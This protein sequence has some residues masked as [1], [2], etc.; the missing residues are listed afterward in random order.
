MP[1]S[2]Q[3]TYETIRS[4]IGANVGAVTSIMTAARPTVNEVVDGSI[5]GGS[6]EYK[7]RWIVFTSGSNDGRIRRVVSD[8]VASNVHT[9]TI[10]PTTTALAATASG[11]TYELWPEG[12]D[13]SQILRFANQAIYEATG[14]TVDPVEDISF[15]GDGR[16]ARYDIPTTFEVL[17]DVEHRIRVTEEILDNA[18]DAWTAGA[19]VTVTVDTELKKVGSGSNKFV[20]AAGVT[21]GQVV[22]YEDI[23]STDISKYTHVEFWIRCSE[24]RS[25]SDL[26]LLLDDT[27]AAT[28]PIETLSVPALVVDT[29]TFVRVALAAAD[30]DTAIISVGL[31]DDVD[32]GAESVWID[33]VRVTQEQSSIWVPLPRHLW[34]IDPEARDLI[35]EEDAVERIDHDLIKLKG[36]NNPIVFSAD[37]DVSEVDGQY[38]IAKATGLAFMSQSADGT[39]KGIAN[40]RTGAFWLNQAERHALKLR[41]PLGARKVT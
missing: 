30:D 23:T 12:F 14:R 25:A 8:T 2:Q 26:K 38:V 1:I 16:T 29:W 35:L 37:S 7:G 9:M 5:P 6:G 32:I 22:A 31:E 41:L 28:S 36:G 4:T 24:A 21:A 13:P 15:K 33:D 20:L 18:D 10:L 3:L 40:A 39:N 19:N 27:S 11:D 34:H 17:T